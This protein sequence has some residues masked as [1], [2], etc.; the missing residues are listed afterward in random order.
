MNSPEMAP[1]L[2][3]DKDSLDSWTDE[4]LKGTFISSNR[5]TKASGIHSSINSSSS[6]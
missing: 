3:R 6:E 1:S 5:E 2:E 4:R